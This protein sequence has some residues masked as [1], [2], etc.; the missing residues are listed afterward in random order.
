[1]A[2]KRFNADVRSARSRLDETRLPGIV[3]IERGDS[4][5]ELVIKFMHK[6]LSDSVRIRLL[7][8][9]ADGYP[10]DNSFLLF[11]DAENVPSIITEAL[12]DLQNYTFGQNVFDSLRD[13]SIS[14]GRALDSTDTDGDT[15]MGG[16][17]ENNDDSEA[18]DDDAFGNFSEV[19]D[20]MFGLSP[21]KPHAGQHLASKMASGVLRKM[22]CDLRKAREFG[23]KVGVLTG[24]ESGARTHVLSLSIRARKLGIPDEALE[25]WD[26]EPSEYIVLLIRVDEPYP[27]AEKVSIQAVTQLHMEFRFG[28]CHTYKPNRNSARRAFDASPQQT[29]ATNNTLQTTESDDRAFKKLFISNSLEQ[30][31]NENFLSLFKLRLRGCST[32]DNANTQL[33]DLSLRSQ[34]ETRA[35]SSK[36]KV[37][38]EKSKGKDSAAG[39]AQTF[40]ESRPIPAVLC[41]DSF[42]ESVEDISTPLVA[43]QFATHYFVRC[44]EYC[45]RCHRRLDKEFEALKPFVCPDPLCLFQYIT[46]GFGPSIEHEIITQPYVV[47][48]LV[49]LCY[50]SIQNIPG[51]APTPAPWTPVANYPIRDF[52][53]GLRLKV[54]L[55]AQTAEDA[56]YSKAAFKVSVDLDQSQI[57]VKKP[58]DLDSLSGGAWVVLQH[59]PNGP[60]GQV[61]S[62]QAYIKYV[63]R[64]TNSIDAQI[65]RKDPQLPSSPQAT[66]KLDMVLFVYNT[67]FDDLDND[68]KARAMVTILNTLPPISHLREYLMRNPHSTLKS[69]PKISPSALTL[70]EWIVASNRSCILQVNPVEDCHAIDQALLSTIKTREQEVIPDMGRTYVQFRFAQGTPDKEL[71][72]HRALNDLGAR[73]QAKHPTLFA[74]HGSVLQNWHS[75]LRQ[76]LDFKDR[77]N[78]RAF[79]NGVYFSPNFATSQ[80]CVFL[81]FRLLPSRELAFMHSS[82]YL[83]HTISDD[84]SVQ[85]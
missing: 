16:A 21:E 1:M 65:I 45:L 23:A 22:K 69:Y 34:V 42:A 59:A 62:H 27:S 49:T 8:Q 83:K 24:V 43:M 6:K 68:R 18:Y 51:L 76:G 63:D 28:K 36:D 55:T 26:V 19:D 25:A 78:G 4:D 58:A 41:A 64:L 81:C 73:G 20:D 80:V 75:I 60:K 72:F 12:K 46:M 3:S 56:E 79:G 11:T 37:R 67:E 47:D 35:A 29:A 13:L 32:W 7:A 53:T 82:F 10:D 44:T 40:E 85:D 38:S 71:R 5:G 54:P 30:F 33:R 77:R 15:H 39:S 9:N 57:T 66:G 84:W 61:L 70:L 14:L 50:A 17:D 31:M 52:P 48:L 2:L 74:W